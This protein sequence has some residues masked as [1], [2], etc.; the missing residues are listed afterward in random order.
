MNIKFLTI[1]PILLLTPS[2]LASCAQNSVSIG[3]SVDG[4]NWNGVTGGSF[5]E[6]D[7]KIDEETKIITYTNGKNISS[8]NL[9]I[10]DYVY[11]GNERYIVNLGDG[12]FE[13]NSSIRGDVSLNRFIT[14]IPERCFH[15]CL[16]LQTLTLKQNLKRVE[17]YAFD[18]CLNLMSIINDHYLTWSLEYVGDYAFHRCQLQL[19]NLDFTDSLTHIGNWA[20]AECWGI[21]QISLFNSS[22]IDSIGDYAFAKCSEINV[23]CLNNSIHT[24]GKHSFEDCV[25]LVEVATDNSHIKIDDFAFHGC[26]ELKIF[27]GNCSFTYIGQ[28][29]FGLCMSLNWK[30]NYFKNPNLIEI[31]GSAFESCSFTSIKIPNNIGYIDYRA[32]SG[33]LNLSCIDLSEFENPSD[34]VF[35]S[36]NIFDGISNIGCILISSHSPILDWTYKLQKAGLVIS[37]A[38]WTLHIVI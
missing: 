17:N 1:C 32:F 28:G 8:F 23:I 9:V 6:N 36:D 18:E 31:K 16:N 35:T 12:C 7:Y 21:T 29:S 27:S 34:L 25:K 14:I 3:F 26:K 20:F 30:D 11:K 24:I 10:P 13:G 19:L 22:K 38:N 2:I 5:T 15:L 33:N 4:S 37:P